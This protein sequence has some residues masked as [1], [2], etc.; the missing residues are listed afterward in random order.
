MSQALQAIDKLPPL[1]PKVTKRQMRLAALLPRCETAAEAMRLAGYSAQTI[2]KQSRSTTGSIGVRRAEEAIAA[3]QADKAR[4]LVAF[5]IKGLANSE[6]DLAALEPR[7][8]FAVSF[9]AIELG[10]AVGENVTASG[11]GTEWERRLRRAI[12]LAY[13]FGYNAGRIPPP[14][15]SHD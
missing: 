7:D 1:P 10:H 3:E 6:A 2:D 11:S 14:A 8:R 5:G 13:R 15:T 9:K 4:G 12:R